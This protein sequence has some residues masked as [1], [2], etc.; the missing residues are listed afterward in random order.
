MFRDFDYFRLYHK[1]SHIKRSPHTIRLSPA[2]KT[3]F[4]KKLLE[5]LNIPLT[6]ILLPIYLCIL[7]RP[8]VCVTDSPFIASI[9]G[10]AKKLDLCQQT[11]Y[12]AGDWFLVNARKEPMKYTATFFLFYYPDYLAVS[13]N[14][15]VVDNSPKITEMRARHWKKDIVKCGIAP[16]PLPMQLNDK[17]NDGHRSN[18]CFLGQVRE[19]KGLSILLSIL[20]TLN[21][22]YGIKFKIFGPNNSKRDNFQRNVREQGLKDLIE[23]HGWINMETDHELIGD[24][25]CGIN[26]L[27]S[28]EN[29]HSIFSTPGKLMHYMQ[30]LIP[31]LITE[32]SAL[33]LFIELLKKNSWGISTELNSEKIK[34][35]IQHLF[36]NQQF[37]RENLKQYA[38]DHPYISI[39]ENLVMIKELQT[40]ED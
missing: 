21:A 12:Q 20:P 19:C 17:V 15:L 13:L 1:P 29:N 5:V 2:I 38:I 33:P 30:N 16:F 18:I 27:E 8:K 28:R 40:N 37:F 14:D 31:P 24:C 25:F 34:S 6:Q 7:Y 23:F 10:I 35:N 26:L 22:K 36:K 3:Q 9:F 32:N 4:L 39:H 11:I